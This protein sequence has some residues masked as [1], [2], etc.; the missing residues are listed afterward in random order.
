MELMTS[1]LDDN[2]ELA[3]IIAD[4]SS[5]VSTGM[6]T[7]TMTEKSSIKLTDERD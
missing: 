7:G 5:Q 2:N 3:T 4:M 6:I 1:D